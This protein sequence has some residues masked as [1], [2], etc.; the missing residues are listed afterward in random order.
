MIKLF[1]LLFIVLLLMFC[2][3]LIM[4]WHRNNHRFCEN[5]F[6]LEDYSDRKKLFTI[7]KDKIYYDNELITDKNKNPEIFYTKTAIPKL[8]VTIY[9]VNKQEIIAIFPVA[10]MF[11][12][13]ARGVNIFVKENGKYKEIF[14]RGIDELTGRWRGV[15]IVGA[16]SISSFDPKIIVVNQDLGQLAFEGIRIPWSDYYDFYEKNFKYVLANDKHRMEFEQMK[17]NYEELDLKS[18]AGGMPE[19]AGKKIS[20]LYQSRK[21][22]EN[23]CFKEVDYPYIS[24]DEATI[25]LKGKKAIELI[26]GGKNLSIDDVK[27]VKL[28]DIK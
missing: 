14:K 28:D 5:P 12:W 4:K 9:S 24:K 11:V 13:Y 2:F 7:C 20:D 17:K 18:C 10:D 19:L 6:K 16:D 8:E 3:S 26:L 27:N 23:F 1:K 15:R 25:F 21:S 22:F